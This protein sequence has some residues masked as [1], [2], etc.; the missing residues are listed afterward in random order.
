MLLYQHPHKYPH[1]RPI[2]LPS[3]ASHWGWPLCRWPAW[4]T[5]PAA[6]WN[7]HLEHGQLLIFLVWWTISTS[8]C[9]KISINMAEGSSTSN[10]RLE[11]RW[12]DMSVDMSQWWVLKISSP[13][14][15]GGKGYGHLGA[16]YGALANDCRGHGGCSMRHDIQL[17]LDINGNS[18]PTVIFWYH[19]TLAERRK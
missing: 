5:R 6:V 7:H 3:L 8:D 10:S 1:V 15:R 17:R 2:N 14:L 9:K 13:M 11:M 19:C 16:T 18:P 4:P 12:N